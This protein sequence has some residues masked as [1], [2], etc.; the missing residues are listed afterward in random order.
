MTRKGTGQEEG[1][2]FLQTRVNGVA[3]ALIN[4]P[5]AW[6]EP[7]NKSLIPTED[8]EKIYQT[9]YS[10]T[11]S[12]AR[13]AHANQAVQLSHSGGILASSSLFETTSANADESRIEIG[14][15]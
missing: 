6:K 9:Q 1:P 12:Q 5:N 15:V 2:L 10:Q 14:V 11:M 8:N 4:H 7:F 13:L 3:I